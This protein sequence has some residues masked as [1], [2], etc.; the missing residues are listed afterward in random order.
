MKIEV[1]NLGKISKGQFDLDKKFCVFVGYNNTGKTY[2]SQ[3]LWSLSSFEHRIGF[4]GSEFISPIEIESDKKEI[5]LDEEMIE[6]VMRGFCLNVKETLVPNL[7][8]VEAENSSIKNFSLE[9]I[10]GYITK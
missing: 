10:D 1:K 6:K 7:F 2:L 5:R 9:F 4:N 8:N 3:L